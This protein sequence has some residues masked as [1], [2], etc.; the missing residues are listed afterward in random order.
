M[1]TQKKHAREHMKFTE[2]YPITRTK[3]LWTTHGRPCTRPA[4]ELG[5]E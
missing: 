1:N 5:L 3:C 4:V 2:S